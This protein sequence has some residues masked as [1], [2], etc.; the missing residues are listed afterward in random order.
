M[1]YKKHTE[2]FNLDF[3]VGKTFDKIYKSDEREVCY[4]TDLYDAEG[5]LL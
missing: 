4:F 2:E 3:M 5:R 1:S